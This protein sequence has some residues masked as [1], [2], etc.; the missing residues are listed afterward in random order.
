LCSEWYLLGFGLVDG[1]LEGVAGFVGEGDVLEGV[2]VQE[3]C[4]VGFK[5][6]FIFKHP[7]IPIALT[8]YNSP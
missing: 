2:E 8:C 6:H 3:D 7:T 4:Y 1:G 5:T